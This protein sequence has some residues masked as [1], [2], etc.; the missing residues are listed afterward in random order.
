[1]RTKDSSFGA[2]RRFSFF[3]GLLAGAALAAPAIAAP[4]KVVWKT[5]TQ[6]LE[7]MPVTARFITADKLLVVVRGGK[8]VEVE[9]GQPLEKGSARLLLGQ[10]GFVLRASHLAFDGAY[11]VTA[12]STMELGWVGPGG[13]F[14]RLTLGA[15]NDLDVADG[16]LA[17]VGC[18]A[19]GGTWAPDGGIVFLGDL[20]KELKDLKPLLVLPERGA[21]SPM[22]R[23]GMMQFGKVRFFPDKT[24]VV[25][26]AVVPGLLVYSPEGTLRHVIPTDALGLEGRCGMSEQEYDAVLKS[27]R[28]WFGWRNQRV[29]VEALV[30]LSSGPGLVLRSFQNGKAFWRLARLEKNSTWKL[31]DLPLEPGPPFSFVNGDSYGKRL[32]L[33][34]WIN[35]DEGEPHLVEMIVLEEI[36]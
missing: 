33:I 36:P 32:L 3:L 31:E 34:K 22:V 8:V 16:R 19:D 28:S 11:V 2:V 6:A 25:Y 1:M 29:L 9:I 5:S 21:H 4:W 30:S 12:A 10:P 27:G 17:L 15:I 7:Q 13:R 26:P 20:K 14:G 23:C 18:R 24:L 35:D